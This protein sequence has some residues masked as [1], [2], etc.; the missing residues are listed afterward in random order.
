MG[1]IRIEHFYMGK[2]LDISGSFEPAL[3]LPFSAFQ[4]P[5]DDAESGGEDQALPVGLFHHVLCQRHRVLRRMWIYRS[6]RAFLYARGFRHRFWHEMDLP[7]SEG[8]FRV[9]S[10]RHD[11]MPLFLTRQISLPSHFESE[12][13]LPKEH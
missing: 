9:D 1:R 11:V 8:L 12:H 10:Y 6:S 2:N 5:L 3:S 13:S 4:Y 7:Q